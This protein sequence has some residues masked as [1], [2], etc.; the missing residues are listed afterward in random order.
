MLILTV[1][2]NL[3]SGDLLPAQSQLPLFLK[4]TAVTL[5][6]VYPT[7]DKYYETQGATAVT[8]R[9]STLATST[10]KTKTTNSGS[11][12]IFDGGHRLGQIQSDGTKLDRYN[13]D[14]VTTAETITISTPGNSQSFTASIYG[15][16]HLFGSAASEGQYASVHLGA[17][18]S[19]GFDI[20][21]EM[22]FVNCA[23]GARTV[24]RER[25]VNSVSHAATSDGYYFVYIGGTTDVNRQ[26]TGTDDLNRIQYF[27][28][29]S[30]TTKSI[31][32]VGSNLYGP[33]SGLSDGN[34]FLAVGVTRVGNDLHSG[35]TAFPNYTQSYARLSV[36]DYTTTISS[37][38]A[39]WTIASQSAATYPTG[40]TGNFYH[41]LGS[42]TTDG[43]RIISH[44]F[45]SSAGGYTQG[46]NTKI[47]Y[48]RF[49]GLGVAL[50]FGDITP[51]T[52][53]YGNSVFPTTAMVTDG[54]SVVIQTGAGDPAGLGNQNLLRVNIT[55][56]A[57]SQQFG[58]T[59]ERWRRRSQAYSGA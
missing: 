7:A 11:R 3:N 2:S 57:N 47:W 14:T 52:V 24:N 25:A 39:F 36:L 21:T 27:S 56:P 44:S 34:R 4:V 33:Q 15:Q 54:S 12:G 51:G 45:H 42:T 8:I 10:K 1:F 46:L 28:I 59:I 48:N 55:T 26:Y 6:P 5:C 32:S 37:G 41:E 38:L 29:A 31:S 40:W 30:P 53:D 58:N 22:E 20:Q 16:P 19:Q 18:V 13:Q 23:T 9:L 49:D 17:I 43:Y 35:A 50:Q